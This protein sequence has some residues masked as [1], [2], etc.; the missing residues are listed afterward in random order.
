MVKISFVNV[1]AEYARDLSGVFTTAS[2]RALA[3]PHPWEAG[4][5][6]SVL[7]DA[8]QANIPL[9]A[10]LDEAFDTLKGTRRS[11]YVFKNEIVSRI[12]FGRHRPTSASAAVEFGVGISKA[13][14]V[15]VNGTTTV[16]EVKTDFDSFARLH[17]QLRDYSEFAEHVYVVVSA[18]RGDAALEA[19]AEHVGVIALHASGRMQTLRPA[20][21]GLERITREKLFQVLR[22]GERSDILAAECAHND[23]TTMGMREAFSRI[24]VPTLHAHVVRLLRRRFGG[25]TSVVSDPGFP[26]SLRALAYGVSLSGSAQSRLLERLQERPTHML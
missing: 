23:G 12:V 26:H 10:V 20:E 11:E 5:R 15:V 18:R 4:R 13:D 14:V 1:S 16:Y 2:L 3:A 7:G 25:A 9:G 6:F 19:A 21:G 24:P 8:L 17:T 22:A